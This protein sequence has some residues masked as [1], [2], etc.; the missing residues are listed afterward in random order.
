M[1]KKYKPLTSPKKFDWGNPFQ[2][3]VGQSAYVWGFD[4][5]FSFTITAQ[6]LLGKANFP[7][8]VVTSI[9]GETWT[10]PQM[11]LSRQPITPRKP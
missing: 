9:K 2:F 7:H 6:V 10:V 5:E 11:H 8:Y 4:Q 3:H 1:R